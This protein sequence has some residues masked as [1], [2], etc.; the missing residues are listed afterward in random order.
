MIINYFRIAL[1]HLAKNRI[2]TGVNLFGL[3]LGFLC[4][5]LLSLYVY[6]ELSYDMFH[7]DADHLYRVVQHETTE[8]GS[9]RDVMV[10]N[11]R[12]G[13]ESVLQI[14]GVEAATRMYALG[15]L[16]VGNEPSARGYQVST[17]LDPN[18]FTIFNFPLVEGN[19]E[20][21]LKQPDGL[22]ISESD[23]KKYFGDGPYV[24]KRLWT[25][26][27]RDDK[28]VE[29]VIGGVFKDLP[30]NTHFNINMVFTEA[31][32]RSISTRFSENIDTDWISNNYVTYVKLK[33]GADVKA[34]EEKM[35]TMVKSNYP[36]D[37]EFR[38]TFTLQAMKDI[39]TQSHDLQGYTA[40]DKGIKPFY[41][42]M[43]AVVALLILAI[44][45]LNYMNLSTASA[46]RRVKEI[47]TRKALGAMK[48]QL[49]TQFTGE[50]IILSIVSLVMAIA[51]LQLVLP[52]VNV[53]AEKNMS[54]EILPP[55][56]TLGLGGVIL[57]SGILSATYP[58]FIISK[59]SA[60]EAFKKEVKIG[61][62]SLPMRKILVASQFAV[63]IMMI[64]CTIVIYRQLN[65]L[66]TKDVGFDKDNVI[67][68]DI[69]SRRLRSNFEQ[70]K[71]EFASIPEVDAITASTRV[72]GEWK[73]FPYASVK[74]SERVEP[75]EMIFVGIDSDFLSTYKI[76]LIAGR[77][78]SQGESDSLKVILTEKAARDLGL[79]DP[80]GALLEIPTVRWGGSLGPLT[81]PNNSVYRVEVIGVAADFHFESLRH[82][83]SP[84][85]FGFPDNPIQPIDYYSIRLKNSN[86]DQ[87]VSKLKEINTKID[88]VNPLEY[89]FLDD[90][91]I[92][93][94]Y[95]MDEKRGQIFL[96]FSSIIICI[97][98]L[99]L[100]ALVSYSIESR[101]KEIGVRKVLGASVANIVTLVSKEF[102]LL[103]V[104]S[105]IIAVPAAWYFMVNWLK[106]FE[107]RVGVGGGVFFMS[108]AAALV[109][110]FTTICFRA[111][112]AARANPVNSLR[113]E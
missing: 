44:A 66:R 74:G 12:I 71:A 21:T 3:T 65:Y 109:I 88:P 13:P 48:S 110:A 97:A 30:K 32:W 105:G 15:R 39:H 36:K 19:A 1:R 91:V 11:A 33:A 79:E 108:I 86:L 62:R 113:S 26:L 46:F 70:V 50:A 69:N 20:S 106:D 82:K 75:T 25:S 80:V 99:G 28:P 23:A 104:V 35:T 100:F 6:D 57:L 29:M 8:D 95:R 76:D 7:K 94:F 5:I 56:W 101:T 111:I 9:V 52:F 40:Q 68:V 24:G 103:V 89:T 53:F 83:M 47:G 49:I 93:E 55:I 64:A 54:L 77:N 59:V 98:C 90:Q 38:S 14:S 2:F 27:D 37:Q 84:I 63:S 17:T 45:C 51:L 96:V 4:F 16:T 42:Y 43:F 31:T 10:A 102:I 73:S 60:V 87:V 18:F 67:V 81:G 107:Y 34:I 72:P 78:F 61:Y 41:I 112:R 92:A 58:A 85:I 22:L